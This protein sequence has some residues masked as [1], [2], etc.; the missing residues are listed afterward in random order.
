MRDTSKHLVHITIRD[1]PAGAGAATAAFP[2]PALDEQRAAALARWR[3]RMTALTEPI[4]ASTG[5]AVGTL[6]ALAAGAGLADVAAGDAAV[7]QHYA[8]DLAAALQAG[9]A[10]AMQQSQAAGEAAAQQAREGAALAAAEQAGG[11]E[12]IEQ[13]Q[14]AGVRAHAGATPMDVQQ[15]AGADAMRTLAAAHA[16]H[17]HVG[18]T[19]GG[20]QRAGGGGPR[21]GGVGG[22]AGAEAEVEARFRSLHVGPDTHAEVW[23]T[24]DLQAERLPGSLPLACHSHCMRPVAGVHATRDGFGKRQ[25]GS[26]S[27]QLPPAVR[28]APEGEHRSSGGWP[29][30]VAAPAAGAVH[31]EGWR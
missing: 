30:G 31:V 24:P 5:G 26:A 29:G 28:R 4:M 2:D 12:P 22:A 9:G 14:A 1:L 11:A 3:E 13:I 19:V 20:A 21:N 17:A 15:A 16:P 25:R 27:A 10:G 6:G 18:D 23:A 7:A 8:A